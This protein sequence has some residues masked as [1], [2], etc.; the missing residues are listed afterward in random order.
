M[1]NKALAETAAADSR[2]RE[3]EALA[4][5]LERLRADMQA[6]AQHAAPQLA[7][8]DPAYRSSACNLLHYVALRKHDLRSLQERLARLGLS[9]LGRAES[10][11]AA[12]VDAM[13]GTVAAALGRPAAESACAVGFDEGHRLLRAHTEELLGAG[14]ARRNT[15]IMVTMPR[16]SA[17]DYSL[18]HDLLRRGMDC[19]RINCAHDDPEVWQRMIDNLRRA[20]CAVQR[21]CKLLMDLGGPK[22]RTGPVQPGPAVLK[23]RPRRDALGRVLAPCRIWLTAAGGGTA[24]P[25]AADAVVPVAS[26]DWLAGLRKGDELEFIDARGAARHWQVTG[27]APGGCFCQSERTCYLVPRIALRRHGPKR[28]GKAQNSTVADLPRQESFILLHQGDRLLLS[29]G[30]A[31]GRPARLDRRGRVLR[32]ASI[33]CLPPECIDDVR[34]GEPIWFDDGRI[35]GIIEQVA[36]G[37]AAVRI[38]HAPERGAKLRGGKGI[39]LPLSRL[40]MPAFTEKD[41]ADLPFVAEHADMVGLSFVD[42]V[43]DVEHLQA[44]IDRLG[45][46]RPAIVLKIETRRAFQHLPEL[47]LAAMRRSRCGVMIARGDLAVECGFER[48][49]EVQEEVLWLCEAAHVP[50]IWATQVLESLAKEGLPSRAEITDAAMGHRAECVML[51]KG[52]HI[53]EAVGALDDILRRMQGHQNK[54]TARLRPLHLA[55]DFS[56]EHPPA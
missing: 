9:S 50:A 48:L 13:L 12:T 19:M 8:A 24:P 32:P 28:R 34:A 52:P 5:E 55:M 27:E 6:L 29:R 1:N 4:A 47:L 31:P 41:R 17:D 45:G 43:E 21:P 11:V 2:R 37:T 18:V 36:D 30:E 39:N 54:K 10:H 56:V 35:G 14:P 22:L 15:R 53:V 23:L 33:G 44:E 38:T 51:N 16:E 25:A 26:S 3:Y 46:R 20:E 7:A 40:R 49:A 42:R